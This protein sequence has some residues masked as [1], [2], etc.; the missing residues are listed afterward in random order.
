MISCVC[1][2][3]FSV[4][5]LIKIKCHI[6]INVAQQMR[7]VGTNLIP[8]MESYAEADRWTHPISK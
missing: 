6:K 5:A 4:L 2:A 7:V 8:K 3:E 1:L